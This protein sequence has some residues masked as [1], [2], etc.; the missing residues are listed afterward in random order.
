MRASMFSALWRQRSEF[1]GLD[2]DLFFSS[3]CMSIISFA[4][5][6]RNVPCFASSS[7]RRQRL[8]VLG[9]ESLTKFVDQLDHRM[10]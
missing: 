10:I 2:D 6:A 3:S 8:I 9:R 1:I 7:S 4:K 5:I